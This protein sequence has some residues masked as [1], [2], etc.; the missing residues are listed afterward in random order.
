M[1]PSVHPRNLESSKQSTSASLPSSARLLSTIPAASLVPTHRDATPPAKTLLQKR[2]EHTRFE[3][4]LVLTNALDKPQP[5]KPGLIP[6]ISPLRPHCLARD[7]LKLWYP[8]QSR[9]IRNADGKIL[10]ITDED[11]QRVLT[12]M[13]ASWAQ[14]TKES[15]GAGLL[16]FHVFCDTRSIPE[17][18]R[19]PADNITIL[20]FIASCAGSYAG[21]TLAN[22]VYAVR[23]WHILHGQTWNMQQHELKTALDGAAKQAPAHSKRAKRE[24]FTIASILQIRDHLQ[25]DTPLDAAVFACLTGAFYS[26]ARLGEFTVQSIKAFN[27]GVPLIKRADVQLDCQDRHGLQVSKIRIP[28]TKTSVNGEDVYWA[29]QTDATDPMQALLKH[30]EVNDPAPN[31][32]IFAWKH[33]KGMRPLTRGAFLQRIG[34]IA[35]NGGC[36]DLK[37][38]GIRIGGTLEYLLRGVPF[39]VVKSMGRWSSEAFTIY[40]RNHAVIM[41]P[42]LQDT[43]I[44]EPFTRYTMAKLR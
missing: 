21:K 31:D 19:C 17:L 25:L 43:P 10:A 1:I 9:S 16:V 14:G 34:S 12:V 37:G 40:L 28:R 35:K 20:T 27:E 23:A 38:H 7:R 15:Y 33:P 4:P 41:A 6:I 18:Q 8:V 36:P 32:H 30:F 5:Y 13:N 39:D 22:Y 29:S 26:L 44:I 3:A 42:Y 11:L 24:P 2:T